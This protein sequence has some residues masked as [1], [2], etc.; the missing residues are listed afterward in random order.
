MNE[1]PVLGRRHLP[2]NFAM[3]TSSPG[4]FLVGGFLRARFCELF[5]AP[6]FVGLPPSGLGLNCGPIA[7]EFE[8]V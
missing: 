4:F 5:R 1:V 7:Y 6:V 3:A 2:L 8:C